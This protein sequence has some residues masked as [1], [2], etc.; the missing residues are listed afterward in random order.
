MLIVACSFCLVA[1]SLLVVGQGIYLWLYQRKLRGAQSK[2]P[3][4]DSDLVQPVGQAVII[5]CV[6]GMDP[7][8]QKCLQALDVQDGPDYQIIVG[9]DSTDDPAFAL[10]Q[11]FA[12][13]ANHVVT[14]HELNQIPRESSL[15]CAVLAEIVEGLDDRIHA[16]ALVDADS[17]VERDWLSTLLIPLADAS[18]G[19][20]TGT[21][22]FE[23]PIEGRVPF[24]TFVRA[25]WNTAAIVQ[26]HLYTIAWGGSLAMRLKTVR[27]LN[28][29]MQW[30][31]MFCED[32][33][34]TEKLQKAGL[35]VLHPPG[36]VVVNR[37]VSTVPDVGTWLIRQLLTVRLYHEDWPWVAVHGLTV[38]FVTV[39]ALLTLI[40]TCVF[41]EVRLATSVVSGFVVYT[42]IS[43]LMLYQVYKINNRWIPLHP[44]RP[45]NPGMRHA[46]F[47]WLM[48]I[49]VTQ[50]VHLWATVRTMF[51]RR[52]EW[53]N[54]VYRC[55]RANV[56]IE[57]YEPFVRCST[58]EDSIH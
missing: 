2:T 40:T 18:V 29:T 26:M 48:A 37:E 13:T 55:H 11:S 4:G 24:G 6:R 16:I 14:I 36:L 15:K 21:R 33:C 49:P 56:E 32:T 30:R 53:R 12:A 35:R 1:M 20:V 5:L 3:V 31:K 34:L 25:V 51:A 27:E 47:S 42:A 45:I 52:I 57:Q 46:W 8:L 38:G 7:S 19:A 58:Q 50:L 22:W 43:W 41:G 23:P 17:I 9:M 44:N 54:V 28:L 10:I 39:L